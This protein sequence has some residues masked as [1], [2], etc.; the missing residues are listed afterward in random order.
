[1]GGHTGG[2][3]CLACDDSLGDNDAQV[4]IFSPSERPL[5]GEK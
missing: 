3:T 1:M 2:V 4:G 5:S